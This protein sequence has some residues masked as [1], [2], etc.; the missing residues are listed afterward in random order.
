MK[1]LHITAHMGAGAGKAISGLAFS[2]DS[3]QHKVILLERPEKTNHL[4]QCEQIGIE[5]MVCPAKEKMVKEVSEADVIVVN[6]WH[7][8]AVYKVLMEISEIPSRLILW[9]HVNGL[10]YPRLKPDFIDCFDACMFT[11][12]A[13][14][15]N[16]SW[17]EREKE[18]ICKRSELVYGM[19]DF[20]P[21]GFKAKEKYCMGKKVLAGY[22]GTLDYAKLHPDFV[23]WLKA[24]VTCC[25][26]IQFMI[27]GDPAPELEEDV[28]NA[29]LS[30]NIIFLGFRTDI[31]KLLSSWD[32]FIY[33]LNPVNFATTE[34][35]LLE[36]MAA[37]LPVIASDG[38][39]EQSIIEDG[40]TGFLV[41]DEKT[42]ANRMMELLQDDELRKSMGQSARQAV[43]K[44]Y[45]KKENCFRFLSVV[46]E[47]MMHPKKK[48]IFASV[49]GNEAFKWFLNGCGTEETKLFKK[50]SECKPDTEEWRNTAD[51]MSGLSRIYKG[52]SKGSVKHFSRYYIDDK[53]LDMLTKIMQE[54][55]EKKA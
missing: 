29:G 50:L 3:N 45:D 4:K 31:P 24:V 47:V 37:G 7:H 19:G 54:I 16:N 6:W 17:S 51:K 11:A 25:Q 32:I 8:P 27:A 9:S 26:S 36:A 1:I 23:E 40:K 38:I 15:Q 28:N 12:K 18:Q 43:I 14:F 33:P 55:Q 42:F 49:I 39:V 46:H 41:S 2:D 53:E 30:E 52:E 35:A 21:Q 13:T 34:N 10:F 5:I 44:T 20:H 48:H 22:V